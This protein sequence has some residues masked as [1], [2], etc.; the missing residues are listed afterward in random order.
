MVASTFILPQESLILLHPETLSL[1]NCVVCFIH[2]LVFK[3][4][5]CFLIKMYLCGLVTCYSN[6]MWF[7]YKFGMVELL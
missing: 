6:V 4:V 1:N 5:E 7:S 2:G 3:T